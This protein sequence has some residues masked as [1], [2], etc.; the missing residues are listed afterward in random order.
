MSTTIQALAVAMRWPGFA[1]R[2][3]ALMAIVAAAGAGFLLTDHGSSA[4]AVLRDGPDLTR[5][6]RSMAV[7]KMMM[8]GAA[9]AGILW[10]LGSAASALWLAGYAAATVSMW[11][12]PGLIWDMAQLKLGALLLHGGLFASLVLLW[13]DPVVGDRLA[14][15]IAARRRLLGERTRSFS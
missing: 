13:R 5:L 10:R 11:V 12:G 9:T 3:V 1:V 6:L 8:A 2:G 15:M 14:A 7:L 4:A